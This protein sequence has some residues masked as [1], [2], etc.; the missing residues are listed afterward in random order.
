VIFIHGGGFVG[1]DKRGVAA[2]LLE[3]C[4][5][6]GISVASINY[7]YSTQAPY[8]GPMHDGARAVQFLR[9]KAR[10]WNLNPKA[11]AASGGSAGT[12]MSLWIGF[13]ADMADAASSDLAQLPQPRPKNRR[14]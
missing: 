3:A 12:G 13:H 2:A 6:N 14:F 8:P 9:S 1:G 7:R 4:L 10:E 5:D 11:F